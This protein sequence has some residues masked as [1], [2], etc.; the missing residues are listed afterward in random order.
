MAKREIRHD[1]QLTGEQ[2]YR[3]ALSNIEKN[4]KGVA[5]QQAL[6]NSQYGKGDQ[7]MAALTKRQDVL[8]QKLDE[9]QKRLAVVRAE[10]ERVSKAQGEGSE[11]ARKLA[12]ELNYQQAAV[13]KAEN[14][15]KQMSS[16]IEKAN[17]RV[18]QFKAKLK[19]SGVTLEGF[20]KGL[21]KTGQRYTQFVS[22]AIAAGATAS[23]KLF[24]DFDDSLGMLATL[25][26]AAKYG[27]GT[28][29]DELLEASDATN[30]FAE[31]LSSATYDAISSGAAVADSVD[32]VTGAAKAAKAGASD[33]GTVIQGSA[34]AINAFGLETAD[35]TS[36]F[37][38]FLVAQDAGVFKI[39]DIASNIGK[40]TGLAGPLEVSLEEVLASAAALTK[41][42]VPVSTSFDQI[43]AVMAAVL[44]PTKEASDEAKRLGLEFSSSALK[45]K[46]FTGFLEDVRNKT[47]GSEDSLAKLFGSV[48][49]LS[50]VM[51]LGSSANEFYAQTLEQ[52]KHSEG[53]LDSKFAARM[54]TDAQRL[55]TEVNKLRNNAI[56]LGATLSPVINGIAGG[57]DKLNDYLSSMNDEQRQQVVTAALWAAAIGP[58]LIG[59]GKLI[60]ALSAIKKGVSFLSGLVGGGG[61]LALVVL[62]LAAITAGV[63]A[64]KQHMDSMSTENRMKAA[65]SDVKIDTKGIDEAIANT[66][67]TVHKM[68][69]TADAQIKLSN[70]STDLNN[71]IVQWLTDGKAETKKQ[72]EEY[73]T[74]A[75][76]VIAPVYDAIQAAFDEKKKTLDEQLAGGIIDKATYDARLAE[77]KTT[78][79][80]TKTSL[81]NEAQAY[82]TYVLTLVENGKKPT[83]EQLAKLEELH[84][85]IVQVGQSILDAQNIALQAGKASYTVVSAGGGTKED[86]IKGV[87]Y[88]QTDVAVKQDT[89]KTAHEQ[90]MADLQSQL[91]KEKDP[92]IKTQIVEKMELETQD[93][94][95][96]K[97]K[98]A[99]D[100]STRLS[101]MLDGLKVKYPE[102]AM[103]LLVNEGKQG[104]IESLTQAVTDVGSDDPEI[105][106]AAQSWLDSTYEK[107]FGTPNFT[108]N[109]LWA[110][111]KID[112]LK[113]QIIEATK[114]TDMS[115]IFTDL[116][117]ALTAGAATGLDLTGV[118]NTLKSLFVA[119]DLSGDG[120]T[121]LENMIAGGVT[122]INEKKGDVSDAVIAAALEWNESLEKT[123]DI[124]SPSG[125]WKGYG[126]DMMTGLANGIKLGRIRV[127]LQLALLTS[128]MKQLGKDSIQG[129]IDGANDKRAKLIS[130]Y[131]AIALAA[132]LAAKRELESKSPS[133][134]F[135]QLGRDTAEGMIIG[136]NQRVAAVQ[137]TMRT[138]IKPPEIPASGAPMRPAMAAA[139]AATPTVIN[140]QYTGAISAR[141]SRRLAKT[142]DAEQ[143]NKNRGKGQW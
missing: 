39:G 77:L 111:A 73:K 36:V 19:E 47:G 117:T 57:F 46:G 1:I 132:L 62:G 32:M 33:V 113:T 66:E 121:V 68:T 91:D 131:K 11:Q 64:L 126:I 6:L 130:A 49:S 60:T 43:K 72:K 21:D 29:S 83:E 22:A 53:T 44:K 14:E 88:L 70:D 79:N 133:K 18:E 35:A 78:T 59:T 65:F 58:I 136:L 93:F 34:A 10:Y 100:Y 140:V 80:E 96:Q 90:A 114:K 138:V 110:I 125:V 9:Q 129:L 52:L 8:R 7:S 103:Q 28:L 26:D 2:K 137:Q 135:M 5:S 56:R 45:S 25:P 112:E 101:E 67:D 89:L 31:Q 128:G 27:I 38:K 134:K 41:I 109:N 54:S 51:A 61:T 99:L 76:E 118:N 37:D 102:A 48:E 122:G 13:N 74:K 98:L 106:A 108:G 12:S 115:G 17:S 123:E 86:I 63:I 20:A 85:K 82:I 16:A 81:D 142:L 97:A 30:T 141:E 120:K 143:Q 124:H 50:A 92:E 105:A 40:V 71:Q 127:T 24:M 42:G 23:A 116:S 87:A 104:F 119:I 15:L 84:Q 55:G 69:I 4:L 94:E 75:A 107:V 139:G 95:A 3:Q